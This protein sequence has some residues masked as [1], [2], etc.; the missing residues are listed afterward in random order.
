[1]IKVVKENTNNNFI[2]GTHDSIFHQDEI[3][4]I[5]ILSLLYEN[6]NVIRSRNIDLLKENNCLLID[7]GN[8]KYDH[9]QINGNGKRDNGIKYASAGLIWKDYGY[10]VIKKLSNDLTKKDI[11]LIVESIDKNVI[12]KVDMI[13]NGEDNINTLFDYIDY[14]LPKWNTNEEYDN[15]FEECIYITSNIFKNI[16]ESYIS[17]YISKKEIEKLINSKKYHKNNILIIP[18]K[19]IKYLDTVLE[20]NDNNKDKIDFI[21]FSYNENGYAAKCV[22]KSKEDLFSQRIPFSKEWAGQR[23]ELSKIS[24]I[25]SAVFC[26]N[27]RFLVRA[28]DFNDI[29]KMCNI[30]TNEY[31]KGHK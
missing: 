14:F 21:A 23:E 19:N 5:C 9:H 15:K 8:G 24:G 28:N 10:E 25:K 20:Y 17:S 2:I 6:I 31:N 22:P 12:Q 18:Y 29:I 30:A 11:D 1:M 4:A 27:E 16:I 26:H 7:I 3:I 13:D